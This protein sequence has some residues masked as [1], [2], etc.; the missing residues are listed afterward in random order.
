MPPTASADDP[1][2][3]GRGRRIRVLALVLGL[4]LV[5][6]AVLMTGVALLGPPRQSDEV[7]M[8]A[9]DASPEDVVT[10][11]LDALN[12]HDCATAQRL[13]VEGAADAAHEWCQDVADLSDIDVSDH[14]AEDPKHTG[15]AAPDEV[16]SVPVTFDLNWRL[17]HRDPSMEEGPTTW[18]YLLIRR[19]G[20]PW[21]IF[22]QGLG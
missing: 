11:F 1:A 12:A 7:A 16:V 19:P 18:G 10:T 21:R 4:A 22:D 2:R 3:R 15:H 9:R 13:T 14:R 20:S 8:P 6:A 5:L 17:L